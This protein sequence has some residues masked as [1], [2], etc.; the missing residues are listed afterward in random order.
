[1]VLFNKI[2]KKDIYRLSPT[3]SQQTPKHTGQVDRPRLY[4]SESEHTHTHTHTHTYIHTHT[5]THIH[6]YTY[7][8]IHTHTHTHTHRER[9]CL[10]SSILYKVVVAAYR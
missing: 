2:T 4:Q 9:N 5:H 6:T 1:M 10:R 7:T 3:L 8:H